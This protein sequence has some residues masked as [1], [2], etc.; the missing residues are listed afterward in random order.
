MSDAPTRNWTIETADAIS[1]L[2]AESLSDADW[3]IV[4]DMKMESE[5]RRLEKAGMA[6]QA[7]FLRTIK[8][9]HADFVCAEIEAGTESYLICDAI[10]IACARAVVLALQAS[11]FPAAQT[12]PLFEA[13]GAAFA[14]NGQ[15]RMEGVTA[16]EEAED[17]H[18]AGNH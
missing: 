12:A 11:G 15:T 8:H 13:L 17:A 2:E 14:V 3:A 9:A 5:C 4:R 7:R 1:P 18:A 6:H 16:I 10:M